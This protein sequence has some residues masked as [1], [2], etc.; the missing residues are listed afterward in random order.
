M[1]AKELGAVFCD[2]LVS[3]ELDD[4]T[5]LIPIPEEIRQF[6]AMYRPSPLMRA[7]RLEKELGTPAKNLL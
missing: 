6:Y 5:R 3:Q 1:T 2:E 7:Y 4:T